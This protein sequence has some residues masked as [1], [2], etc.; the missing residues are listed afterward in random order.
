MT[1]NLQRL[2]QVL[3]FDRYIGKYLTRTSMVQSCITLDETGMLPYASQRQT[4]FS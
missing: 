1:V 4:V 2:E 3:P